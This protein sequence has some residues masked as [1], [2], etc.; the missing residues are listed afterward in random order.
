MLS[1]AQEAGVAELVDE[2]PSRLPYLSALQVLSDATG[3]L[4]IGSEEPH[5]TASK[6]FPYILAR[7]PLLTIFHKDS[8][9]AKI[10]EATRSGKLV[11]FSAKEPLVDKV[12]HVSRC[13]EEL[14]M[15]PPNYHPLLN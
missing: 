8:S 14:L 12:E 6:I 9:I 7:K 15:L 13:L 3:L 2:Q 10:M 5:Y 11:T 1:I 4:V